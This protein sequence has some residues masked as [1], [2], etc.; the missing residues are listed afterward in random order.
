MSGWAPWI[1]YG[2][3]LVPVSMSYCV[4]YFAW[5]DSRFSRIFFQFL[6]RDRKV[7]YCRT[8]DISVWSANLSASFAGVSVASGCRALIGFGWR[9]VG[10][11]QGG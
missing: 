6:L 2:R 11:L 7:E 4:F 3:M 5:D 10:R 9:M 1:L 8:A